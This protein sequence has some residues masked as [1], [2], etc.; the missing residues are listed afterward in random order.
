MRW[1][2]GSLVKNLE[3]VLRNLEV[4]GTPKEH[5]NKNNGQASKGERQSKV[6][7]SYHGCKPHQL[8]A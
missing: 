8:T 4:I 5:T 3:E 7:Y 6:I 2:S 1:N